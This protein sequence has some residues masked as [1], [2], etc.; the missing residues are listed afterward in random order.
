MALSPHN[1]DEEMQAVV[2]L[3]GDHRMD[4]AS[5]KGVKAELGTPMY[6]SRR[7]RKFYNARFRVAI[8]DAGG[9]AWVLEYAN[10]LEKLKGRV[11]DFNQLE[12]PT[13]VDKVFDELQDIEVLSDDFGWEQ[14]YITRW[15]SF[16]D[17]SYLADET[18]ERASSD[19]TY[20]ISL[21]EEDFRYVRSGTLAP[22]LVLGL[23]FRRRRSKES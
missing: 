23:W 1:V 16:I 11:L 12:P 20:E 10:T 21:D 13:D 3:V 4:P 7:T 19:T 18:F 5:S 8:E 17:A 15:R 14:P 6:E 22:L 9:H 2:V